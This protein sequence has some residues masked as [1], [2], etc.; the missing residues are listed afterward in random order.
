MEIR[1]T[2]A[3]N[4]TPAVNYVRNL[5]APAVPTQAP[6][7]PLEQAP[8]L[9]ENPQLALRSW[10]QQYSGQR[11]DSLYDR[12]TA[13]PTPEGTLFRRGLMISGVVTL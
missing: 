1:N 4:W 3:I 5:T 11:N 12:V 10:L 6:V 9:S 7:A 13:D 2:A 8:P